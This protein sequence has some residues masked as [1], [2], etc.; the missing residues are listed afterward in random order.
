MGIK[1]IGVETKYA[2]YEELKQRHVVAQGWKEYGDLTFLLDPSEDIEEYFPRINDNS[3]SG[4]NAFKQ[5][6][7][8][9]KSGDILLALEGNQIKGIAEIPK[10]FTYC[11]DPQS[12]YSNSLFPVTWIDWDSF[13][14]DANLMKQGGQGAQGIVNCGLVDVNNYIDKNWEKYKKNNKI[15]VQPKQCEAQLEDLMNNLVQRI[16]ETKIKYM[17][18]LN[19]EKNSEM[20]NELAKILDHNHNLILAGAPG[21]G[22]TYNTRDLALSIVRMSGSDKDRVD[23]YDELRQSGQI[24][25]VTFHQSMDYED[26]IEGIKSKLNNGGITYEVE[27]GVFKRICKKAEKDPHNNYVLII[28]EI[29]RGNVSKIFGELISL[30]EAD[31]RLG[32][33]GALT[34]RLPYSK[35]LFGVPSNV[36]LIG[37]M[38]TTDRSVGSVDYAI[39]RRFAFYTLKSDK[40]I[41]ENSYTSDK[42][43]KQPVELFGA[44]ANYI[45]KN[46]TE[47][48]VDDLMVGHSYFMYREG[49]TIQQKWTYAILPL[50]QEYYKDGICSKSPEKEMDKFIETYLK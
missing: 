29:N 19:N 26:F 50:L 23:N 14:K 3:Q 12:E 1:K 27:D 6:F 41:V 42:D 37:T 15:D 5:L 18:A 4:K 47:M 33:L 17:K 35:E 36:Y 9:I 21:T 31:K 32:E 24:E 20:V 34:A 7:R 2:T 40:S 38:N 28:D 22:K 45:Q 43:K 13:C 46:K 49:E 16:K 39:R 44:V 8:E 30:I 48:D 10:K 25:F 11:Y